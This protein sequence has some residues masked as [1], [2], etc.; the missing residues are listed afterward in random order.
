MFQSTKLGI[1]NGYLN[2]Q[3]IIFQSRKSKSGRARKMASKSAGWG[4]GCGCQ[5]KSEIH[6]IQPTFVK[7]CT[8]TD[9]LR[10]VFSERRLGCKQLYSP[11][12]VLWGTSSAFPNLLSHFWR[13][14]KGRDQYRN[15][16]R[17]LLNFKVFYGMFN[18]PSQLREAK[19]KQ[20]KETH[21]R[22]LHATSNIINNRLL[23]E[24]LN[25]LFKHNLTECSPWVLPRSIHSI[26]WSPKY[27]S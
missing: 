9:G 26:N 11:R 10:V 22:R 4:C 2:F 7:T 27:S 5:R 19:Q 8:L 17:T 12:V 20:K 6:I 3:N 16:F 14:H 1:N 23:M 18:Q 21:T 25:A 15:P 13:Y 24:S